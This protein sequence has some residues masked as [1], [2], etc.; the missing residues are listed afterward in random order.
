MNPAMEKNVS[1]RGHEFNRECLILTAGLLVMLLVLSRY[2]VNGEPVDIRSGSAE[3]EIGLPL[4]DDIEIRQPMIIT[5]E[6]DWRQGKVSG[7]V[8]RDDG[9]VYGRYLSAGQ[10]NL[11][12]ADIC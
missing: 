12:A 7:G 9:D 6:M 11:S 10:L 1:D 5:K 2:V 8:W 4:S 3:T